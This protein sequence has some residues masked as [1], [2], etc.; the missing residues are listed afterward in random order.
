MVV[1]FFLTFWLVANSASAAF[2]DATATSK[3]GFVF[4]PSKTPAKYLI[5]AMGAEWR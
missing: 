2:V 3:I 5:E 4:E 1:Q